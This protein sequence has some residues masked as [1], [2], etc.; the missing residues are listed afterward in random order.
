MIKAPLLN[1]GRV[2]YCKV[3]VSRKNKTEGRGLNYHE[4]H[5]IGRVVVKRFISRLMCF[6][7]HF[8]TGTGL[9]RRI[10]D[11]EIATRGIMT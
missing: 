6:E 7:L 5:H 10:R 11:V 1:V 8:S 9:R 3:L 4:R 2:I